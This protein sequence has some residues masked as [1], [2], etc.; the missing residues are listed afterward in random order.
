[1][2]TVNTVAELVEW[3]E[4][5]NYYY[6]GQQFESRTEFDNVAEEHFDSEDT[7]TYISKSQKF[8]IN[9]LEDVV[10]LVE[11]EAHAGDSGV[12]AEDYFY[13]YVIR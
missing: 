9:E 8:Y 13:G 12:P 4:S 1:M 10:E 7:T 5:N 2:R 3:F 11:F 6:R